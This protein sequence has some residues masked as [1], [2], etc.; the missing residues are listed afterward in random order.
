M[1]FYFALGNLALRRF[2]FEEFIP[3]I[4]KTDRIKGMINYRSI[5]GL[6]MGGGGTFMYA[7]YHPE[8]FLAEC[9]LSAAIGPLTLANTKDYMKGRGIEN[10]IAKEATNGN[11]ILMHGECGQFAS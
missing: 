8:M 2:L 10:A 4:E 6:L 9:P 7:L 1:L 11:F 5:V 3:Y